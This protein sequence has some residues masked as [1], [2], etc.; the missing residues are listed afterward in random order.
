MGVEQT[1]TQP[2][3]SANQAVYIV[4]QLLDGE[5]AFV[6]GWIAVIPRR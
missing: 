4:D 1:H 6:D 3:G 2:P 5:V